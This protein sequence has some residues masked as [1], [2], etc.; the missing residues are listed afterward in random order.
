MQSGRLRHLL[1]IQAQSVVRNA[2]NEEVITFTN[3]G[4]AWGE[5]RPAGASER[6]VTGADQVQASVDHAITI[7]F[8]VGITVKMRIVYNGR[9]FDIEGITDPDGRRQ[10]LRLSC[11]EVLNG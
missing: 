7:R 11:R 2:Y 3:W 1:T 8:V 10:R 6:I 5:I 4:Q 9:T